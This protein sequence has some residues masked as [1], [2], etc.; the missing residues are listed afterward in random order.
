MEW[1]VDERILESLGEEDAGR[2]GQTSDGNTSKAE[3]NELR[4]YLVRLPY[5]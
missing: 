5:V 1:H 3:T 2:I 4:R